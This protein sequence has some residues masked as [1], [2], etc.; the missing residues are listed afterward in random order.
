MI[1]NLAYITLRQTAVERDNCLPKKKLHR[2]TVYRPKLIT[3][4]HI[5][6]IIGLTN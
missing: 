1:V 6:I 4:S 5:D 2:A 3:I